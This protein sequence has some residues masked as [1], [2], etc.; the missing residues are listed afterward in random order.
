M[1]MKKTVLVVGGGPEITLCY[2]YIKDNADFKFISISEIPPMYPEIFND[3]IVVEFKN[4]GKVVEKIRELST[5]IDAVACWDE[6]M[7][8]IAD[9]ISKELNL[10]PI[11]KLDS[12]PFRFKDR[13]R[14]VCEATG[15]KTPRYRI[16]DQ[17][18]DTVKL[19]N[20]EYPLIVKPTSFLSSIGVKKVNNFSEL[21]QVV[22]QLLSVKFPVYI[23]NSVYELG[24]IYNLE[25]RVLVEEYIEGQEY[26][27][28]S[29]IVNSEYYPLGITQKIV[30]DEVFMDEVGH[31]FPANISSH[32]KE[33]VLKWGELLH[34]VLRLYNVSS[35]A[36]FRVD[37]N[38]EI[39]LIEIGARIGGDFIPKLMTNS[40]ADKSFNFY[41]SYVH[42]RMGIRKI[43]DTQT[44][45]FSGIVFFKL[46]PEDYGKK[47]EGI[48]YEIPKESKVFYSGMLK[49]EGSVL[50]TPIN[51]SN[52]RFGY[53]CLE[54]KNYETLQEEMKQLLNSFTI[55][56]N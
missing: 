55:K 4:W 6:A 7:T 39:Y 30:D 9:D 46:R 53:V 25:P 54:N 36:E 49:S 23:A 48:D 31:I 40:F 27:L 14:M 16:I 29:I 26:S 56:K 20:W 32:L 12:Q 51:W 38:G 35:H 1:Q 37:K 42:A 41:D 22:G 3:S 52:E 45:R 47:F 21:Q 24:D 8:H 13:M 17:F 19:I 18:S 34:N 50:P 10:S 44:D 15:I 5:N 43:V 33:K 28:E 2:D 11:S